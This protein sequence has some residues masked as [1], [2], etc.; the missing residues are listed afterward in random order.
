MASTLKIR[1]SGPP[2][3]IK[4]VDDSGRPIMIK[5]PKTGKKRQAFTDELGP[6]KSK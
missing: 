5:D 2:D 4:A 6:N 3:R 1:P